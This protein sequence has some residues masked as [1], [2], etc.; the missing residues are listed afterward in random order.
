MSSDAPS[1][2][3]DTGVSCGPKTDSAPRGLFK[4]GLQ[5]AVE[6]QA[7]EKRYRN[8]SIVVD[9]NVVIGAIERNEGAAIDAALNGRRPILPI[10]AAGEY[11]VKGD[12]A[13][14]T[15]WLAQRGGRLASPTSQREVDDLQ[16]GAFL[17]GVHP[18]KN[19]D[20][21][22]AATAQR[23]GVPVLTKDQNFLKFLRRMQMPHER[24]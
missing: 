18:P 15:L 21:A 9:A 23:E 17:A 12:P 4:L 5:S 7:R 20:A 8:A 16:K 3:G 10:S 11:L 14:L 2:Y 1:D 19:K 24:Y 22:V 6:N 13:Q